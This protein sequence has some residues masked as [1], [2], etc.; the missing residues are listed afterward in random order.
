MPHRQLVNKLDV[1]LICRDPEARKRFEQDELCHDTGTL[2]G[3][4]AMLDRTGDLAAGKVVI[5]DDAG[6][7]GVTRIW[8]GHGDHD[9]ITA[10]AASQRLADAL[11]VKDKEF[12][13]YKGY[14]H[15]CES[16]KHNH[17]DSTDSSSARRAQPRQGGVH[18]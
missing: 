1:N 9:G 18:G 5:P 3:L 13:P 10:F 14:Y 12:K 17:N 15:R 7:G 16:S 11:Q 6:E 8:M 2:E 4:A